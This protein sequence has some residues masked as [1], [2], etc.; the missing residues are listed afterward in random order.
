MQ[1]LI[2]LI[3]HWIGAYGFLGV[4]GAAI[5]EEVIS[6]IPSALVQGVAG[7]IL[8]AGVALSPASIGHFLWTV[9]FASALGVTIGSLPYVWLARKIGLLLVEKYGKWIGVTHADI[10]KLRL[11]LEKTKWDSALFVGLRAFPLV[12]SVALAVYGGITEMNIFKYMAL[13]MI[14]VFI[15]ATVIGAIGWFAGNE[16]SVITAGVSR[17]ENLGLIVIIFIGASWWIWKKKQKKK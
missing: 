8:F 13:S 16:I 3:Q 17:L 15:R 11:K 12:P 9:S 14:G 4:F 2:P 5:L 7:V 1:G 6:P 10:E